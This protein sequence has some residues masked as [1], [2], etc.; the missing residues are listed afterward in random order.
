MKRSFKEKKKLTQQMAAPF[1]L[2]FLYSEKNKKE[3]KENGDKIIF[4]LQK[5]QSKLIGNTTAVL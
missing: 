4:V 1:L 3:R 5:L 2:I